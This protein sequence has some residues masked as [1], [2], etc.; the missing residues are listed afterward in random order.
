MD[1]EFVIAFNS[2]NIAIK[3]ESSLLEHGIHVTVMPLP[4]QIKAGCG[5]CLRARFDNLSPALDVLAEALSEAQLKEL[6]LYER[7]EENGRKIYNELNF[8]NG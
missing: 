6:T 8:F 7:T 3:A 4:S 2:T 5:I 1:R